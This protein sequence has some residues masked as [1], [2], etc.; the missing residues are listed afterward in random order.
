MLPH[1]GEVYRDVELRAYES[2]DAPG[3][4]VVQYFGVVT[5]LGIVLSSDSITGL[6]ARIDAALDSSA[7]PRPAV[8]N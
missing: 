5:S 2:A 4:Q 1:S 7:P 6:K 3:N 8:P